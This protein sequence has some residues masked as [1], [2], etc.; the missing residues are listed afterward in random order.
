VISQIPT[1]PAAPSAP[2]NNAI[3]PDPTQPQPQ[4][5]P[6]I[7][8]PQ[9][10]DQPYA[11]SNLPTPTPTPTNPQS[12]ASNNSPSS[13]QASSQVPNQPASQ[14]VQTN[15]SQQT[16]IDAKQSVDSTKSPVGTKNSIMQRDWVV[17]AAL[18]VAIISILAQIL[19]SGTA[20]YAIVLAVLAIVGIF[21]GVKTIRGPKRGMAVAA[22][23]LGSLA[24]ISAIVQAGI[25]IRV[26]QM[27]KNDPDYAAQN[28][29]CQ[30]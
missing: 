23:I 26:D 22:I 29:Q 10:A 4:P 24:L 21:L 19:V 17:F 20:G 25:A 8:Q 7:P 11:T 3:P 12:Q 30:R 13:I 18:A 14:P 27:C 15:S 16:P 2:V 9:Q 1:Q 6:A 5:N 28:T